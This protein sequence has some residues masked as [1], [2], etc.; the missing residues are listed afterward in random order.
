MGIKIIRLED[1]ATVKKLP[2]DPPVEIVSYNGKPSVFVDVRGKFSQRTDLYSEAVLRVADTF[3]AGLPDEIGLELIYNESDY[4]EEKFSFLM[5][6]ILLAT[7]IVPVFKLP[8]TG[9]SLCCY[10]S[11]P[12]CH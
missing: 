8:A 4:V 10:W 1:V 9:S 3:K 7:F 2:V 12:W 11:A 5:Q 6:S